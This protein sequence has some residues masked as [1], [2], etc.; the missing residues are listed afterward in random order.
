M[1]HS[2]HDMPPTCS[3]YNTSLYYS[4]CFYFI[5]RELS[6]MVVGSELILGTSPALVP[7]CFII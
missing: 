2:S 1:Y 7:A 4:E 6:E 3:Q 5:M